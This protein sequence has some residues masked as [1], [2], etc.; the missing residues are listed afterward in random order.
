MKNVIPVVVIVSLLVLLFFTSCQQEEEVPTSV[1]V[2]ENLL[3]YFDLFIEEGTKR[4][5]EVDLSDISGYIIQITNL[6]VA[7]N[8]SRDSKTIR[9][10]E[11]FWR[12]SPGWDRERVVFHELGHCF[13]Q[14]GHKNSFDENTN[15]CHSIMNSGNSICEVKYFGKNRAT[16]LDELFMEQ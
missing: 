5:V 12:S 6:N 10:D 1:F 3:E 2:D 8:C 9:I 11:V 15:T 4:G 14:R 7:G 13:L 16:Y